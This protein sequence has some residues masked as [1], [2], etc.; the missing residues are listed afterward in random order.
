MVLDTRTLANRQAVS[1]DANESNW[2][3][4]TPP[5]G[6]VTIDG[7]A[8]VGQILMANITAI[9]DND[10]L[11]EFSYQWL[12]DGSPI[13]SS[14]SPYLS[15]D[16][17]LGDPDVGA[18]IS[19]RVSYIDGHGTL[20]SL[21]SAATTAVAGIKTGVLLFSTA[22]N[23]T[24]MGTLFDNDTV[25][26]TNATAG[27]TVSLATAAQQD[28][29]GAGRDTLTSIENLIGS[30]YSDNFKGNSKTNILNGGA[31]NDTLNGGPEADTLRGGTGN[32]IYFVDNAGDIVTEPADGGA[33]TV[34]SSVSYM[35]SN[36]VE[37]L[38]LTGALAING[39]GNNLNNAIL[40][41]SAANVLNGG[42]GNDKLDGGIG[43]N[44]LT[45]GSGRDIFKITTTG[46]VDTFTDFVVADDTTQLENSVFTA[47]TTL[48]TLNVSQFRIGSKA[49]DA[50]DFIIYN[51]ATGKLLY[52][53]DG[54]SG[55]VAIE[56]ATVGAGLAMTNT[57]IVVI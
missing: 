49:L 14:K 25:S 2:I 15:Y 1:S 32:D 17:I 44:T 56:I 50:N 38:I 41:N 54:S 6:T 18:A 53:A 52:D 31:G 43:T 12:R 57:D 28:T 42:A 34:N 23:D 8:T 13:D 55:G 46:H 30:N 47:L 26:Y 9:A 19:V 4:N 29:I 5:T 24:L 11:G 37:N 20:E 7:T 39:T 22:G 45:G 16:L 21:T 27:I 48:G 40:G 10:G 36:N 33:D 35:L 3:A 51:S